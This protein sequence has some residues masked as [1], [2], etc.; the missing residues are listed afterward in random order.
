VAV[1]EFESMRECRLW[2]DST[3]DVKQPDWLDGADIIGV[4][5]LTSFTSG[6]PNKLFNS[7]K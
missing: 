3:P 4:P 6:D 2:Y 7:I 1:L 5:M